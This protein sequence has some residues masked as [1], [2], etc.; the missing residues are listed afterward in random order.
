VVGLAATRGRIGARWIAKVAAGVLLAA[1]TGGPTSDTAS[2]DGAV[3]VR[4]STSVFAAAG[5]L[6]DAKVTY[7][8][9]PGATPVVMAQ[10]SVLVTTGGTDR[11]LSLVGD[12][13]PC[14]SAAGGTPCVLTMHV[15]LSRDGLLLDENVQ[16]LSVSANTE[17]I[18]AGPLELYEVSTVRVAPTTVTGFQPGDSLTLSATALDRNGA[19][20]NARTITWTVLSGNVS[21]SPSGVLTALQPGAAVIR[22]TIGKRAQDLALSVLPAVTATVAPLSGTIDVPIDAGIGISFSQPIDP[23]TVTAASV[24]VTRNGVPVTAARIVQGSVV[25]IT[26]IVPLVEFNSTYVVSVSTAVRSLV[27][28]RLAAPLTSTFTTILWDPNYTYR[29]TTNALGNGTSLGLLSDLRTCSMEPSSSSTSQS[30]YFLPIVGSGGY[31]TMRNVAAGPSVALEG[32]D[33]PFACFLFTDGV[34]F[35]GMIWRAVPAS[36]FAPTTFYLQSLNYGAAKA[37]GAV[38]G[39]PQMLPTGNNTSQFWTFTRLGRR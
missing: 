3:R 4:L 25:T 26:P 32:A 10:D 38:S 29:L 2:G 12:V 28:T 1:C 13:A 36:P 16:Q 37:L 8:L 5:A 34:V 19:T 14:V 11:S 22:A 21:V 7:T 15:R 39:V 6:I 23:S 9:T 20:V 30:W 18:D 35:T 33:S 27:G 24:T 17:R 31:F